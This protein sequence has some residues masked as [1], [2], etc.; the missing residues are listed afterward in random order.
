MLAEMTGQPVDRLIKRNEGWHA[1]MRFRQAGLLDLRSEIECVREIAA[2]EEMGEPIQDI[3][4]EIQGFADLTS[5]AAAAISDDVRGHGRAVFA[6]TP[7]HFLDDTLAPVA[8]RQIE[9]DIGPAF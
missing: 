7:V 4:R 8:A 2:G 1:R 6:V 5:R 3:L 9:I